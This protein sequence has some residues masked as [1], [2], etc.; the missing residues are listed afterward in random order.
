M[1]VTSGASNFAREFVGWL[2][3]AVTVFAGVYYFADIRAITRSVFGTT[4]A[5]APADNADDHTPAQFSG[6]GGEVHLQAGEGG[7]FFADVDVNGR[8]IAVV[9]DT[10]AT[11]VALTY[12]DARDIGLRL[13]ADDFNIDSSTANG[14]THMAPVT[15]DRVQIGDIEVRNVEAFGAERGKLFKTLL[16]MSFLR[17]PRPQQP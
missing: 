13:S 14:T 11:G 7:H 5:V 17:R 15:L 10:G 4:I 16:G 3:I 6:S 9:V 8:S 1:R 12:E 2:V